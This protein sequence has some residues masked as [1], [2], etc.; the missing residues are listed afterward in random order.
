[1]KEHILSHIK[2]RGMMIDENGVIILLLMVL[3]VIAVVSVLK[4]IG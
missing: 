1:M 4:Y 2:I 3:F